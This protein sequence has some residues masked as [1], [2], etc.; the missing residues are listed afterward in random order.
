MREE[1]E[2]AGRTDDLTEVTRLHVSY[3]GQRMGVICIKVE[4]SI[5]SKEETCLSIP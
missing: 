2:N 3:F 5:A 1:I 4:K